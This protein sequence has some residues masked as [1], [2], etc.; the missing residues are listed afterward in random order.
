[1]R[2]GFRPGSRWMRHV[3][4]RVPE[5]TG[6]DLCRNPVSVGLYRDAAPI[7]LSRDAGPIDLSRDATP[8]DLCRDAAPIDLC[9]DLVPTALYVQRG[10]APIAHGPT[11]S[12]V[13]G[14]VTTRTRTQRPA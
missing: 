7:D 11:Q 9:R 1:M 8:I 6:V 13:C 2:P 14:H 3:T 12:L 10:A 4:S 5:D